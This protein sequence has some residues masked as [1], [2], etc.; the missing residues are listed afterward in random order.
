MIYEPYNPLLIEHIKKRI[1]PMFLLIII[2]FGVLVLRIWYLQFLQKDVLQTLS[3]NNRIRKVLLSD[4]RGKILDTN[5]NVIVDIRPSFNL[6]I[7]PEDAGNYEEI[8]NILKQRLSIDENKFYQTIKSSPSY[9]DI[10]IERDLSRNDVAFIEEHKIDLPG[11]FFK[12][13]PLRN[14]SNGSV[15]T[16]VIGYIGEI[17]K[18]QLAASSKS[19][20]R[21]GDYI[22]QYGLE[23]VYESSLRGKKGSKEIEVDASGRELK[24]LHQVFP[25]QG[26]NLILTI[27]LEVQKTV[28]KLVKGKEGAVTVLDPN[29][30]AILAVASS[31]S[32][33]PNL[34]AGKFSQAA[35]NELI[36]DA[37]HPLQ[38]RTIQGQYAPGSVYKIVTAAAGLGEKIIDEKFTAVCNGEYRLG[39]RAYR[40]WKKRGHGKVDL[41]KALV[42]SCDVYFYKLGHRIGIDTLARYAYG[43][44]LGQK[45]GFEL[46]QEKE[47]LVPSTT[48][49]IENRN[50]PWYLGETISASIG[51]SYNLVTPLQMANLI[52]A[53]AN[54][55]TL[56]KPYVLKKIVTNDGTPVKTTSPQILKELPIS[57]EHLDIIKKALS[58]VVLEKGGTGYR[59][60]I[61]GIKVSG[62]TGTSQVIRMKSDE[63]E[64]KEE[65]VPYQ[66]RDH[67]WFVAFAPAENPQ[68]AISVIIEHG[69][70]GGSTSAPIAREIIKKYFELYPLKDV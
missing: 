63:E 48:W 32:F 64:E 53:V 54:G 38:N 58:G 47:G 1:T 21:Q 2:S 37:L 42:Q 16:H 44:G 34:F 46:P 56:W 19:N 33:D 4:Y 10:L 18:S 25:E 24:I 30:G 57:K 43:F 52:G 49:K 70:H 13:E 31:P 11:V 15:A 6:Y 40:C 8:Y 39:R 20:Y 66:F 9:K 22:G 35:W 61:P 41:H 50:E 67:A 69:G 62:K 5:N 27:D 12:V 3:E 14:Y 59:A 26:Q 65:E 68:I 45:A 36:T 23:K 7:T 60:R 29:S 51:Q 55:G 28:E 17:S